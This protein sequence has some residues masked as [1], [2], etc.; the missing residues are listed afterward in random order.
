MAAGAG[1]VT[2]SAGMTMPNAPLTPLA[3]TGPFAVTR[4]VALA[5]SG[6]VTV[7]ARLPLFGAADASVSNVPPPS[8]LSSTSTVALA[9]RLSVQ[10]IASDVP[11][12]T[13]VQRSA[14]SP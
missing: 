1:P 10:V 3:V 7:Q 6:P 13:V 8:R 11:T 12:K 14:P 2:A 5:V 9:G 4:T